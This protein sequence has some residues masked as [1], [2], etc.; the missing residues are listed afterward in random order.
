MDEKIERRQSK[1]QYGM[2]GPMKAKKFM[3]ETILTKCEND[4]SPTPAKKTKTNRGGVKD[5]I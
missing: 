1:T 2:I 5:T 3:I 4:E